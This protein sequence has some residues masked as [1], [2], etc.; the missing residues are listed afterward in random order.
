MIPIIM[1]LL[2]LGL[3]LFITRR[4]LSV[5]DFEDYAT[6]SRTHRDFGHNLR[7]ARHLVRRRH[8]HGLGGFR[9]RLRLHRLLRDALRPD[10]PGHIVLGR[11]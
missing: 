3:M 1:I 10:D 7:C 6:A 2:F 9:G 8:L 5:R 4:Q 11:R